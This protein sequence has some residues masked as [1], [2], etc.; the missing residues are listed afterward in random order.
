MTPY[1]IFVKNYVNWIIWPYPIEIDYLKYSS[2]SAFFFRTTNLFIYHKG[3]L[4]HAI[5]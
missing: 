2:L 5:K 3:D 4:R 1:I